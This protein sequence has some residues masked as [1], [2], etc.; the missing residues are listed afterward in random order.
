[1]PLIRYLI[2]S[3]FQILLTSKLSQ[4]FLIFSSRIFFVIFVLFVIKVSRTSNVLYLISISIIVETTKMSCFISVQN[5]FFFKPYELC[6]ILRKYVLLNKLILTH[7]MN[8]V[9]VKTITFNFNESR[10]SCYK[11][12]SSTSRLKLMLRK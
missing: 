1:M 4:N 7:K 5:V 2:I 9:F 3:I 10:N 8:C 12:L 11:M 6:E